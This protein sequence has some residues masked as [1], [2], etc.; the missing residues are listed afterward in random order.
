[1]YKAWGFPD[2]SSIILDYKKS[3][4]KWSHK[5]I[6]IKVRPNRQ[7]IESFVVKD[8]DVVRSCES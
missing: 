5:M 1:M 7:P 6:K 3:Y 4:E 2:L 8:G